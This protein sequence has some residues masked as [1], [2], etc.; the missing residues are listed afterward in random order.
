MTLPQGIIVGAGVVLCIQLY[1]TSL[2]ASR[3]MPLLVLFPC[4]RSHLSNAFCS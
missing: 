1:M 2:I 4:V 3:F